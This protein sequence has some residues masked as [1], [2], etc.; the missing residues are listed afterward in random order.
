V[1]V[2][3]VAYYLPV[4]ISGSGTTYR[5]VADGVLKS[6]VHREATA[7]RR[8][9]R[10]MSAL[11]VVGLVL[12][13]GASVITYHASLSQHF[14]KIMLVG[15]VWGLVWVAVIVM[16]VVVLVVPLTI[17]INRRMV[18]RLFPDGSVTEVELDEDS[19]VLRRPTRTRSVPYRAVIRLRATECFLGLA[20]RG[21][22]RVELL[23]LGLLPDDAIEFIRAR[24]RGAW[25]LS[26]PLGHGSAT[27]QVVVPEGWANHVAAVQT[28]AEMSRPKFWTRVGL[29]FLVSAGLAV[30]TGSGW[31]VVIAPGMALFAVAV[32]FARTRR[33]IAT[34]M[35][36][37]SVAS[38]EFLDDRL[39]S[40]NARWAR[41][42]RFD[43]IRAVDGRGDV[44]FLETSSRSGKIVIA[45]ALIPDDVF[46]YL[47]ENRT[48]GVA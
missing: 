1:G 28:R 18:T 43:D 19:L 11:V 9:R 42:I 36:T 16:L 24:A 38:T 32:T 20:L 21:R 15:V 7:L 14:G 33:A 25:P 17:V 44:V 13:V 37:G 35:P 2:R 26:A 29:A 30:L 12:G 10:L 41:E 3:R 5:Y 39:I 8:H 40:R 46:G 45:R 22:P 27:R 23:P 34:A 4:T 48:G 6:Q 31:L 47:G